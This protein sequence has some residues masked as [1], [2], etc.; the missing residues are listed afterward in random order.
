[1]ATT[2]T[3]RFSDKARLSE[4]AAM[5]LWT[6]IRTKWVAEAP[7][8]IEFPK[9]GEVATTPNEWRIGWDPDARDWRATNGTRGW[10]FKTFNAMYQF[11]KAMAS[12]NW[13]VSAV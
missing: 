10:R 3:R 7:G 12:W 2:I 6:T 8:R 13:K 1:M 4:D 5:S 9:L 11:R